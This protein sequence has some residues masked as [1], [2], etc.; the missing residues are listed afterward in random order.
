MLLALCIIV[1]LFAGCAHTEELLDDSLSAEQPLT[2]LDWEN[3]TLSMICWGAAAPR[4]YVLPD[5]DLIAGYESTNAIYTAISDDGGKT[6][7]ERTKATFYP[8]LACANVNFFHD[9]QRL[10]LA[11]RAVGYQEEGFY[12]SLQ[13]SVSSDNGKS[14]EVHSTIVENLEISNQ[15]RGVWEPCLGILNGE[16]ACFYANDSRSITDFQN[17]ECQIWRNGEWTDRSVISKGDSHNSRDGMPVWMQLKC[18]TYVCVIESTKYRGEGNSMMIQLL[19]SDDG[20]KWSEP[21]DIFRNDNSGEM[22]GAPGIAELPSGQL[23]ISF[24]TNAG[25]PTQD[26]SIMWTLLSDGT[27]V[28]QLTAKAFGSPQSVFGQ[29]DGGLSMWTGLHYHDGILYAA[30]GTRYGAMVNILHIE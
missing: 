30:A 12:S 21:V 17:I 19:W 10:Y 2:V 4:V 27:E 1:M 15:F 25:T 23:V 20:V 7:K 22:S 5:G 8:E 26:N 3:S 16:L 13:I 24:Q 9:G 28:H 29:K 6:W 11:Y 18:G 14:W